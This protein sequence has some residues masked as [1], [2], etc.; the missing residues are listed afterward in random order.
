MLPSSLLQ[1]QVASHRPCSGCADVRCGAP[2]RRRLAPQGHARRVSHG[3]QRTRRQG[4]STHH[5]ART[6]GYRPGRRSRPSAAPSW[7]PWPR[8]SRWW[9][10][11][12]PPDWRPPPREAIALSATPATSR[13]SSLTSACDSDGCVSASSVARPSVSWKCRGTVANTAGTCRNGGRGPV[14]PAVRLPRKHACGDTPIERR[15]SA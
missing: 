8:R 14:Q 2:R 4:G 1:G 6:L 7:G 12:A 9:T 15:S 5:A 13:D 3:R 11:G 10:G